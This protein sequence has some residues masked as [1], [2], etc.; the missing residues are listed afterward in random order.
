MPKNIVPVQKGSK[1]TDETLVDQVK[2]QKMVHKNVQG[3][4]SDLGNSDEDESIEDDCIPGFAL[5]IFHRV[6]ER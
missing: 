2:Q 4:K 5:Y 6:L 1:G 3:R